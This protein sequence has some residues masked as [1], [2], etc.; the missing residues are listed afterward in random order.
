MWVTGLNLK[1]ENKMAKNNM[2][3][4]SDEIVALKSLDACNAELRARN[5]ARITAAKE[6]MG[7]KYVL[8]PANSPSKNT[9]KAVLQHGKE[10]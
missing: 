10:S 7:T 2:T 1:L 8:H 4:T 5:E 9:Y 3:M 6:A